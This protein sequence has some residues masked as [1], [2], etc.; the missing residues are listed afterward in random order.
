MQPNL[1]VAII[2]DSP[3]VASDAP[4]SAGEDVPNGN[5]HPKPRFQ[6]ADQAVQLL[7]GRSKRSLCQSMAQHIAEREEIGPGM[8]KR[9]P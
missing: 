6:P 3:T 2:D 1:C 9:C 5:V 8:P 4:S 7:P